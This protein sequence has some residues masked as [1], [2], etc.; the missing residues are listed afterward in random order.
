MAER[1][2]SQVQLAEDQSIKKKEK[3][4]SNAGVY[5]SILLAAIAPSVII[6]SITGALIGLT[7]NN[8]VT[9][10]TG[11]PDLQI[12]P[13]LRSN[14]SGDDGSFVTTGGPNAFYINFNPSSLTTI[15]SGTGKLIP[16]LSS[17]VMGLAAF[18][19]ADTVRKM[20][21]EDGG[22]LLSP[23]QLA[24]LLTLLTGGWEALWKA[25]QYK[26]KKGSKLKAP[27]GSALTILVVTTLLGLVI[28]VID[29]WFGIVVKP[30][31]Q[32]QVSIV[33]HPSHAFG[34]G[35][36]S[37]DCANDDWPC[38][39]V[40]NKAT[41]Y[42]VDSAEA[43]KVLNNISSTHIVD[44]LPTNS[45]ETLLF[46]RD[47]ASSSAFD[48][49]ASTFAVSTQCQPIT[50]KC[51]EMF[52]GT[53]N[54]PESNTGY[55][56]TPAFAGR[57]ETERSVGIKFFH[58]A[59]LDKNYTFAYSFQNPLY[60]GT[61]ASFQES[62]SPGLLLDPE[63]LHIY[64]AHYLNTL[65]WILNCSATIYEATY[66]WVNGSVA[67]FNATLANGTLGGILS[68]PFANGYGD[69]AMQAAANLAGVGNSSADIATTVAAS[70]S[71]SALSLSIGAVSNRTNLAEQSRS[72]VLLTRVPVIPFYILIMFNFIYG[73]GNLVF[74][75]AV[76]IWAHPAESAGVKEQL[77]IEG[78]ATAL[79]KRDSPEQG[80]TSQGEEDEVKVAVV[81][82]ETGQ[83]SYAA[84][85]RNNGEAVVEL[86]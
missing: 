65:T 3:K 55:S 29:T 60:F 57:F 85:T 61:W 56:C 68:G 17:T 26:S 79:F 33:D 80:S 11:L 10:N 49:K 27:V 13:A 47:A 15:A 40:T 32:A 38:D 53:G 70:F 48:Y 66:A 4:K 74:A 24:L 1:E 71:H 41:S 58:D 30:S 51:T 16:Y 36:A 25:T 46:L 34:R 64:D 19:A 75:A 9:I 18:L 59:G 84:V 2:Y 8:R 28:P 23:K 43:S 81:K 12:A 42:L 67:S 44:R 78:L 50:R 76:V 7:L 77:T 62:D 22:K 14:S 72:T 39:I 83:W 73:L 21:Q 5:A 63:I 52:I 31:E 45:S 37:D 20:S 54:T 82:T 35:L 6:F 69:V 86:V